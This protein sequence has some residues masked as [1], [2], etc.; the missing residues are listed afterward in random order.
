MRL[1]RVR[2]TVRHLMIAV[3]VVAVFLVLIVNVY[4]AGH[5]VEELRSPTPVAG[6]SEA[7]LRLDD[8][9][10]V[11]LPGVR[12][13]PEL[14]T[15]LAEATK[16]GVELGADG[17]VY[18]LV[19]V[20]HWCGNDP[21]REHIARVDLARLLAYLGPAAAQ[22]TPEVD[23]MVEPGGRFTA[24][25]WNV[26]EFHEFQGW[27]RILESRGGFVASKTVSASASH[28]KAPGNTDT[29]GMI[30]EPDTSTP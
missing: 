4:R 7:G 26:S 20:H 27:C 25:G 28:R 30:G 13:T 1:P 9:R 10:T 12:I 3:A 16:R 6:W 2:F 5:V 18:C 24:W 15:A 14:S 17:R 21:V 8:G 22:L 19:R 23:L 29:S 11:S